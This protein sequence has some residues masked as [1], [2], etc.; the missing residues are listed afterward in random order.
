VLENGSEHSNL[1]EAVKQPGPSWLAR[2]RRI[3]RSAFT[4]KG[5]GTAIKACLVGASRVGW[6]LL[7][8]AVIV[9]FAQSILTEVVNVE[10]I[11]VPKLFVDSGYT[12]D[13]ASQRLR[14]ALTRFAKQT[15]SSMQSPHLALSSELPKITVPKVDISLDTA[16]ALARNL[17]HLGNTR[18][19]S[20]EFVLERD[21][22]WLRLRMDGQETF[23]GTTT[24]FDLVKLDGLLDAAAPSVV[25]EIR[26]YLIASAAYKDDPDRALQIAQGII[27][28]LP[29]SD[30][31]VQW[32]YVLE[33]KYYLDRHKPTLAE[34]Y[35]RQAVN[36]NPKNPAA[37]YS[38]AVALE[39]EGK[40]PDAIA[41]Y[42]RAIEIQP[43]SAFA[44]NNLGV[45]LKK[46]QNIDA[47]LTEY[48]L[49]VAWDPLYAAAHN[50]LGATLKE[51][52][53]IPEAIAAYGRA[54]EVD[55][56]YNPAYYNLGVTFR[57]QGKD[58]E[59]MAEFRHA[60]QYDPKD[61][62]SHIGLASTLLKFRKTDEA[63]KE[64]EFVIANDPN[65]EIARLNIE[66]LRAHAADENSRQR[67]PNP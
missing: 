10:P 18:N 53:K 39:N 30:I 22:V 48:R 52:G 9:V 57:D 1:A 15:G 31:N 55:P 44:H 59:A 16:T 27:A 51:Q 24:G 2:T 45:L 43:S 64:Y 58:E 14:D 67:D 21:I 60:V 19:I 33:G 8:I 4:W 54:I 46:Q 36:I 32:S 65:N 11:S 6:A 56:S 34:S 25:R 40:I 49:A 5:A 38:L 28:R 47:A 20:G 62:L 50:N 13:V 23:T 3:L 26:P 17:L 63:L 41:E 42:R 35:L 12:S 37:H 7:G 66:Y 61:V 29:A